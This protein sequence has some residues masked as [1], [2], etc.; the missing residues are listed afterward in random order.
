M[1][2]EIVTFE[3]AAPAN[4]SI[5]TSPT[6]STIRAFLSS[7]TAAEGAHTAYFGQFDEKPETAVMFIDWDSVA[8]HKQFMTTA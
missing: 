2:T 6:A 5:A 8:A 1:I 3:L 7:V 4:L